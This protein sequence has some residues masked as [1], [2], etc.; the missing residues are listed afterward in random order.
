MAKEVLG[1]EYTEGETIYVGTDAKGFTFSDKGMID[2]GSPK[3]ASNGKPAG[4]KKDSD[5]EKL[6]K[7]TKDVQ[8]AVKDVK[9]EEGKD[10]PKTEK[11]QNPYRQSTMTGWQ[12]WLGD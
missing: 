12:M 9:K 6:K 3:V 2:K 5:L 4:K 7:A 8:D 10:D 1:G 11:E